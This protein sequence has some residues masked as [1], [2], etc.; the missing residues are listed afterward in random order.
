M[1]QLTIRNVPAKIGK[2]LDKAS[3][4]TGKSINTL[5]LELLEKV[6]GES[7]LDRLRSYATW[8]EEEA[9]EFDES[10]KDMRQIDEDLWR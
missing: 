1:R 7:R 3:R 9:R 10:I 4:D 8:T 5:V 2:R 6:Y